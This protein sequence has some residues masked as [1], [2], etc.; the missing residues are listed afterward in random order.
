MLL[1]LT[2][3]LLVITEIIPSTSLVVPLIGE[4]L[5]FTMILVTLSVMISVFVLNIH[6]RNP[7]T[8]HIPPWI[9]LLFLNVLPR[10]LLLSRPKSEV[11]DESQM[12]ALELKR[13]RIS[14][15]RL[16]S[17]KKLRIEGYFKSAVESIDI[18]AQN[19][20]EEE[21]VLQSEQDWKFVA[22]VIDRCFLW[23]FVLVCI[24]GTTTLF[25]QPLGTINNE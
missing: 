18:I 14:W 5:L 11:D 7:A 15:R 1:T 21:R 24:I 23:V 12:A 13:K 6:Y 17:S 2:V 4:Y 25:V 16:R 19:I 3:F 8:H 22:M 20:R 10:F 9:R